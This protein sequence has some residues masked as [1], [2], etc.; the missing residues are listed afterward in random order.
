MSRLVAWQTHCAD[1]VKQKA[2]PTDAVINE[3]VAK[4][5]FQIC[6]SHFLLLT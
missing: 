5:V 4:R 3:T 2:S 6:C 1:I